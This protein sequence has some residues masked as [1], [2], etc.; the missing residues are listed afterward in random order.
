MS[1]YT[2]TEFIHVTRDKDRVVSEHDAEAAFLLVSPGHTI[3]ME[4][5][6]ALGIVDPVADAEAAELAE[7][8]AA[9]AE[10]ERVAASAD[11]EAERVAA[12]HAAA[13][14]AQQAAAAPAAEPAPA[15]APAPAEAAP[16]PAAQRGNR[17]T[18]WNGKGRG[19]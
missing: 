1:D 16:A 2:A 10:A 19:K 11:A 4:Q 17:A 5:A 12:E 14:A 7:L 9:E 8:E 6:I 15:T 18:P 13:E 3:P